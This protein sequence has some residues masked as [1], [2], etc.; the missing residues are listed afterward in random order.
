MNHERYITGLNNE[1]RKDCNTERWGW[2][3]KN[4]D[5]CIDKEEFPE[6]NSA[7]KDA[8]KDKGKAVRIGKIR[9]NFAG[10]NRYI[11]FLDEEDGYTVYLF[12]VA[13]GLYNKMGPFSTLDSALSRADCYGL[14]K[15]GKMTKKDFETILREAVGDYLYDDEDGNPVYDGGEEGWDSEGYESDEPGIQDPGDTPLEPT[16]EI[17]T[18]EITDDYS[19]DELFAGDTEM[20]EESH[21][22]YPEKDEDITELG[23]TI[24][25]LNNY[26]HKCDIKNIGETDISAMDLLFSEYGT[27][28]YLDAKIDAAEELASSGW[29]IF[30]DLD[31]EEGM[32]YCEAIWDA[33]A[34]FKQDKVDE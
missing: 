23:H 18:D 25:D 2:L 33:L 17:Y 26:I 32:S 20:D 27:A 8:V 5:D 31:D 13:N 7:L 30:S 22:A 10:N 15:E 14:F 6:D 16:D 3:T 11:V 12:S 28:E 34:E 1:C 21:W 4:I 19:D 9:D 24:V 29:E